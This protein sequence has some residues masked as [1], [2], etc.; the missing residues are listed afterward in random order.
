MTL[1]KRKKSTVKR[2]MTTKKRTTAPK[3]NGLCGRS[4]L[5]TRQLSLV[6][7]ARKEGEQTAKKRLLKQI[8]NIFKSGKKRKPAAKRTKRVDSNTPF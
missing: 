3:S 6:R 8:T 5:A 4:K 1:S 2:K 7:A